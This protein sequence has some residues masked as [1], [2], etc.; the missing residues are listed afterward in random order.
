MALAD[1]N[2]PAPRIPWQTCAVCWVASQLDDKSRAI[3]E[4]HLEAG[5]PAK[6]LA[7]HLTE[8][9]HGHVGYTSV[10]RHRSEKHDWRKAT[11]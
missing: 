3:L 7:P 8:E 6:K 11:A 5:T 4:A 1:L 9:G 2:T 10:N